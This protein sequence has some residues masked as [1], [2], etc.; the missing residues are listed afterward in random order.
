M[1]LKGE[2][3]KVRRGIRARRGRRKTVL[4]IPPIPIPK[5]DLTA[6]NWA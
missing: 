4:T 2:E 3:E 1:Q 5:R 6:K